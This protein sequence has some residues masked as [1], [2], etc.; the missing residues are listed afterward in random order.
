V[1]DLRKVC[2]FYSEFIFV[3]C[4]IHRSRAKSLFSFQFDSNDLWRIAAWQV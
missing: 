2:N 1:A 3:G 4:K